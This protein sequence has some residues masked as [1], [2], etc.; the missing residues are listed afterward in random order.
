MLI[1]SEKKD[2]LIIITKIQFSKKMGCD[3]DKKKISQETLMTLKIYFPK[4]RYDIE[5]ALILRRI[6]IVISHTSPRHLFKL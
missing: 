1:Y 4:F 6:T 3:K 5:I 2:T